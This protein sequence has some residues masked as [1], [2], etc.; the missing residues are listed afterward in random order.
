MLQ[1]RRFCSGLSFGMECFLDQ[2]MRTLTIYWESKPLASVWVWRVGARD[3]RRGYSHL[4]K[5]SG[6]NERESGEVGAQL[7]V[8]VF[9][10]DENEYDTICD[11]WGEFRGD[12]GSDRHICNDRRDAHRVLGDLHCLHW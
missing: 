5:G 6:E 10:W 1:C 9:V 2:V 8:G 12:R 7:H 11:H 4:Q 3:N